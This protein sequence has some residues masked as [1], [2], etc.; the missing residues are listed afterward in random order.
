MTRSHDILGEP[1]KIKKL[2]KL[3]KHV[4]KVSSEIADSNDNV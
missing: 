1:G 4:V 2:G 3:K